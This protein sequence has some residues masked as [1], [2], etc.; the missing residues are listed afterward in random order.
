MAQ[1]GGDGGAGG[2]FEGEGGRAK[3]VF[4]DAEG[5]DGYLHVYQRAYRSEG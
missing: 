1:E 4:E 2:E 5:E 3:G